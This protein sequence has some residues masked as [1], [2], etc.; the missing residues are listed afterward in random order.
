MMFYPE[1]VVVPWLAI[2]LGRPV[3]WIEDREENFYATT[4]ERGQVHRSE[5]AV[6]AE[7]RILGVKDVFLHDAAYADEVVGVRMR[8]D[9]RNDRPLAQFRIG[10]CKRRGRSFPDQQHAEEDPDQPRDKVKEP[11]NERHQPF[12]KEV[13]L[14][15][16]IPDQ[17]A[18]Q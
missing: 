11:G 18:E 12:D 9:D 14:A 16:S 8:V 2:E 6:D 13:K 1:E 3:K 10:Q 7:G 4:Q 17:R 5:I 15:V